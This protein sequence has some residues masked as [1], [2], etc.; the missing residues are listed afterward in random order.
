VD[1]CAPAER[2]LPRHAAPCGRAGP[3]N[4]ALAHIAR[5]RRPAAVERPANL[6][7][8]PARPAGADVRIA[9]ARPVREHR[10]RARARPGLTA[11]AGIAGV[12]GSR[13]VDRPADVALRPAR[14]A[15]ADLAI[16]A[17][18]PVGE[19]RPRRR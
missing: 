8:R 9:A 3:G 19:L 16:A 2:G 6:A 18:R 15:G 7:L 14:P 1:A 10:P 5:I 11:L 12:G 17:A 13:G 4:A